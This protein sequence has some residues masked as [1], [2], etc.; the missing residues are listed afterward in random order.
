MPLPKSKIKYLT[1]QKR[2]NLK[3]R[4]QKNL[5][6]KLKGVRLFD[7]LKRAFKKNLFCKVL[8]I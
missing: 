3:Y 5:A 7:F 8:L 2:I 4:I 6:S 1:K